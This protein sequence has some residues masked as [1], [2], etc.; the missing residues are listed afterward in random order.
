[1]LA[2]ESAVSLI[3]SPYETKLR[4]ALR[5]SNP[6]SSNPEIGGLSGS[7]IGAVCPSAGAGPVRSGDGSFWA[8]ANTLIPRTINNTRIV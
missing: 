7:R 3:D 2:F 4:E 5:I 1:L 8:A 6:A